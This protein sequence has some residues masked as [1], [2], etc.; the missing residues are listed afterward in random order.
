MESLHCT[1]PALSLLLRS[2][3]TLSLRPLSLSSILGSQGYCSNCEERERTVSRGEK[4]AKMKERTKE[5]ENEGE[6]TRESERREIVGVDMNFVEFL[7]STYVIHF[8]VFVHF[9]TS[10]LFAECYN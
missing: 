8:H 9:S 10:Q 7:A 1:E 5:R 4:E 2:T 6:K 3:H